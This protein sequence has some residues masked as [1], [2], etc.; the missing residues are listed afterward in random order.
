VTAYGFAESRI[1]QELEPN[2]FVCDKAHVKVEGEVTRVF[3]PHRDRGLLPFPCFEVCGD[4]VPGMSGGPIFNQRDQ[5]CGVVSSGGI[6]GISYGT[7]LWPVLGVEFDGLRLLDLAR[8]GIIRVVNHHCV[9][10][11]ESKDYRF[12]GMS[13]DP[14]RVMQT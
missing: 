14:N 8:K 12:P 7:V 3:F 13:F 4:F 11:H 9:T 5:V 1:E 6:S 2:S 10:I